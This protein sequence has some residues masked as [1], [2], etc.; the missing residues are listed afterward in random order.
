ML[1]PAKL[2]FLASKYKL[3]ADDKS[4]ILAAGSKTMMSSSC[5]HGIR[6]YGERC[7]QSAAESNEDIEKL[8]EHKVKG[9]NGI[10]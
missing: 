7:L 10:I 1:L 2:S 9:I 8:E 3:I 5:V 6:T 4:D